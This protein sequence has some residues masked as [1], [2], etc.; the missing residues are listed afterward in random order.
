MS[1]PFESLKLDRSFIASEGDLVLVTDPRADILESWVKRVSQQAEQPCSLRLSPSLAFIVTYGDLQIAVTTMLDP[2]L[3]REYENSYTQLLNSG[4]DC[5]FPTSSLV[6]HL[7]Y[8][9]DFM[10]VPEAAAL[11]KQAQ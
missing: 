7:T 4:A 6:D 8:S 3:R 2:S 11:Y 9:L 1:N 5:V 10:T